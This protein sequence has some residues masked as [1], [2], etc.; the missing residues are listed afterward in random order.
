M[1][2]LR[3]AKVKVESLVWRYGYYLIGVIFDINGKYC[4]GRELFRVVESFY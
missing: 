4:L 1:E 3:V 2:K